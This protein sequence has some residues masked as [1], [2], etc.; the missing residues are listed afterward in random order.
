MPETR[1]LPAVSGSS[2]LIKQQSVVPEVQR[3]LLPNIALAQ[4]PHST[5]NAAGGA[6]CEAAITSVQ[7]L[8]CGVIGTPRSSAVAAQP[9]SEICNPVQNLPADNRFSALTR[10]YGQDAAAIIPQLRLCVV[11]IGGVG[12]WAA[13]VLARSSVG[14]LKLIDPDDIVESNINRQ[15]HALDTST[16]ESKVEAM[17]HRI[18]GINQHCECVAID[19]ML[20]ETNLE[21]Y[22]T[23]DLDYVIDAIDNIRFKAALINF[24][25]R[26]KIRIITPG[27]AGGRIDPQAVATA[28]LSRTW[29]DALAAKVR[30]RLRANYGYSRNPKRRFGV[31]CVF[32]SEQPVYPDR[33]GGISQARPGVPGATLDCDSGY[34]SAAPVTATFGMIAAARAMNKSVALR[35]GVPSLRSSKR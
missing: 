27:G 19:D 34:G 35:L 5:R 16:G 11:G 24:C 9:S 14:Y 25:R 31:E 20:V 32:S 23:P 29:N 3:R 15:V 12:S 1:N 8:Y 26:N 10:V 6:S 4:T 2:L 22:I 30:S 21:R 7:A 28:D 17:Q 18:K 33:K 13:E